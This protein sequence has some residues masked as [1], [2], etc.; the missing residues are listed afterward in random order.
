M[1]KRLTHQQ[2][3]NIFCIKTNSLEIGYQR[4]TNNMNPPRPF[5]GILCRIVINA[6]F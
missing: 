4:Y 6:K 2:E 1:I 3:K 5:G